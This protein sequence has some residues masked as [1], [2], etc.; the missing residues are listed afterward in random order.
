[1]M[2]AFFKKVKLHSSSISRRLR[3]T[4]KYQQI[5]T[6]P[7]F[8]TN[9]DFKDSWTRGLD[10]GNVPIFI[11]LEKQM[12]EQKLQVPPSWTLSCISFDG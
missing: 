1:M 3:E 10:H 11:D 12:F 4:S 8:N 7:L 5:G 2:K 6:P 9:L